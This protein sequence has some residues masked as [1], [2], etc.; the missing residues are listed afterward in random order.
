MSTVSRSI[1]IRE[2]SVEVLSTVKEVL[3]DLVAKNFNYLQN[4]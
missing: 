1:T 3:L 2:N 4:I